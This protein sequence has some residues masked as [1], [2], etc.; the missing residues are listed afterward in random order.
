MEKL[1]LW[2]DNMENKGLRV[3]I[4]KTKVMICGKDLDTIK[5]SGK[6][7]CSAC[8]KRVGRN[9]I[10][11][12]SCDAWVHMKCSE[13][14][15]RLVDIP[16]FKCHR[17][18][19]VARPI[20]GRTVEHISLGDQRLEVAESFVYLEDGISPNGSCEASTIARIQSAWGKFR[21]LLPWLTNQAILLISRGKVYNSCIRSAML[22]GCECW[23]LTTA[24]FVVQCYMAVNV[25][26]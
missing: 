26:L 16:D 6:Y 20:D 5:P 17:R 9:S 22:Y 3:N 14:K 1:K 11:C 24:A 4:G 19:G 12:T 25:G 8:R 15:G 21:K 23:T 18:L 13:I 10:F 7:P 2:K